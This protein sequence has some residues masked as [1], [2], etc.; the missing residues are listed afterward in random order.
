[1][2]NIDRIFNVAGAVGD[3]VAVNI[4]RSVGGLKDGD[5]VT[6]EDFLSLYEGRTDGV[7]VPPGLWR[8]YS[9]AKIRD[10][11]GFLHEI[12]TSDLR[13]LPGNE[14]VALPRLLLADLPET[15][16]WEDDVVETFQGRVGHVH[17]IDYYDAASGKSC[18][19]A[20]R[21][22]FKEGDQ[23]D[24]HEH[25]LELV[26]RGNVWRFFND[27]PLSF[28]HALE[29]ARFYHRIS[30]VTSV[31]NTAEAKATFLWDDAVALLEAGEADVIW[32]NWAVA[33]S[34]PG[35][36]VECYVIDDPEVGERC[37]AAL[38]DELA[39]SKAPSR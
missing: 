18:A 30:H 16:F 39:V 11:S 7:G 38:I 26:E 8:N 29:E 22:R 5:V 28:T 12:H 19:G 35:Y 10:E 9:Y 25:G 23:E 20:Y 13:P 6:I 37:R 2:S 34:D 1:M 4:E 14:V 15:S 33:T 17:V 31:I 27:E 32:H 36:R 3:K 21:V 24:Y